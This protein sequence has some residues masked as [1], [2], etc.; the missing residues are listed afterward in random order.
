MCLSL[1]QINYWVKKIDAKL[2]SP[3]GTF[4]GKSRRAKKRFA[5]VTT[6]GKGQIVP[7]LSCAISNYITQSNFIFVFKSEFI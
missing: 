3:W 1:R 6:L 2:N 4:E 7:I 5:G